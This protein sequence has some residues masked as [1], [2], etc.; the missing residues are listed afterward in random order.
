MIA[1][2]CAKKRMGREERGE[3][4]EERGEKGKLIAQR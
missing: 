2:N 3:R 1:A 4:R